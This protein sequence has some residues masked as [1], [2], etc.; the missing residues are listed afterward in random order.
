MNLISVSH[1]RISPLF[2]EFGNALERLRL[3]FVAFGPAAL[4]RDGGVDDGH[5]IA[6][7]ARKLCTSRMISMSLSQC[8]LVATAHMTSRSLKTSTSSSR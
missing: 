4:Q 7:P 3:D 6:E 1:D 2:E 8:T 5:G